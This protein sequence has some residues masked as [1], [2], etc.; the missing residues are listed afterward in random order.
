MLNIMKYSVNENLAL[1]FFIANRG[2]FFSL[3][4][5]FFVDPLWPY[6]CSL[7]LKLFLIHLKASTV[8]KWS[9]SMS[10]RDAAVTNS[11]N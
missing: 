9:E 6:F 8:L 1:L 7:T 2:K 3:K 5:I 11:R 4:L 10:F